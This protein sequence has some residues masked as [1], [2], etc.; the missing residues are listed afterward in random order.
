MVVA[1][2]TADWPASAEARVYP[3][4]VLEVRKGV[5]AATAED[6]PL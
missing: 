4:P 5:N 2:A 3:G 1:S 6:G